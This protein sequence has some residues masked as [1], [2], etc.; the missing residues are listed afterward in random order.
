MSEEVMK[1]SG[2]PNYLKGQF[3]GTGWAGESVGGCVECGRVCGVWAGV[4][5]VGGCV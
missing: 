2:E 4:L 3:V 1:W 5:N